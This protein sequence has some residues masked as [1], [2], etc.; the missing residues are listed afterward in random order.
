MLFS[1]KIN[2]YKKMDYEMVKSYWEVERQIIKE[3]Q[4]GKQRANKKK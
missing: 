3:E 1:R 4:K 2:I